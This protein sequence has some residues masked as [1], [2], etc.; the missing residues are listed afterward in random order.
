MKDES[1]LLGRH[2]DPDFGGVNAGGARGRGV[3][4]AGRLRCRRQ[5]AGIQMSR[6]MAS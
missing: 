6:R 5:G 1:W 2:W 3:W 4:G